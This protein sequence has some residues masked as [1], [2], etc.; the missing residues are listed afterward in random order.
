MDNESAF[1]LK[2]QGEA[3]IFVSIAKAD[4]KVSAKEKLYTP[5]YAAKSQ[6]VLN[7]LKMNE[8]MKQQIR[9]HINGIFNNSDYHGWTAQQH[10]DKGVELLKSAKQAGAWGVALTGEKNEEAL[11]KVAELDSF[12]YKESVFLNEIKKRLREL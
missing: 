10:L 9:N 3:H 7:F 8:G 4:G 6:K 12:L 1:Q 5:H 11:E 2:S